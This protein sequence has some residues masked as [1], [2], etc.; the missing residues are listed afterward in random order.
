MSRAMFVAA[1][2]AA[3]T[4][5]TTMP[6]STVRTM[7]RCWATSDATR[8]SLDSPTVAGWTLAAAGAGGAA[9]GAGMAGTGVGAAAGA[10]RAACITVVC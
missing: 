3:V 5:C 2:M 7:M 8:L 9:V 10:A 4:S 6:R 1:S